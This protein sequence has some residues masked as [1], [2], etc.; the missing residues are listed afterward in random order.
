MKPDKTPELLTTSQLVKK[1]SDSQLKKELA[2]AKGFDL[3]D[4]DAKNWL[5]LLEQEQ[6]KRNN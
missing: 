3:Q 6:D 5:K 2:F 1:L 4:K